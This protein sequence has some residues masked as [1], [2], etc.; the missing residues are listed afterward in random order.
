VSKPIRIELIRETL[1]Y[2][3]HAHPLHYYTSEEKP[4]A[5]WAKVAGTPPHITWIDSQHRDVMLPPVVGILAAMIRSALD[6]FYD[7]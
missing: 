3:K 7:E 6:R 2:K 4:D 1:E 5:G